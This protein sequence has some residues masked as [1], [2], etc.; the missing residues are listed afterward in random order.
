MSSKRPRLTDER[1]QELARRETVKHLSGQRL[2]RIYREVPVRT[3]WSSSV[4]RNYFE[5]T[6]RASITGWMR[7]VEHQK[8]FGSGAGTQPLLVNNPALHSGVQAAFTPLAFGELS[9]SVVATMRRNIGDAQHSS[10]LA[11]RQGLARIRNRNDDPLNKRRLEVVPWGA[12]VAYP[13]ALVDNPGDATQRCRRGLVRA[14]TPD[15]QHPWFSSGCIPLFYMDAPTPYNYPLPTVTHGV[16]R[17]GDSV[18]SKFRELKI[19]IE[20]FPYLNNVNGEGNWTNESHGDFFTYNLDP[21]PWARVIIFKMKRNFNS[22]AH[23]GGL[24]PPIFPRAAGASS[25]TDGRETVQSDVTYDTPQYGQMCRTWP[26]SAPGSNF[27]IIEDFV[28]DLGRPQLPRLGERHE[29]RN[30]TIPDA[31]PLM[32]GY[33]LETPAWNADNTHADAH[34]ILRPLD[35]DGMP[36]PYNRVVIKREYR[37]NGRTVSWHHTA[38]DPPSLEAAPPRD[39]RVQPVVMITPDVNPRLQ[40]FGTPSQ[41]VVLD[42]CEEQMFLTVVT[43]CHIS[44]RPGITDTAINEGGVNMYPGVQALCGGLD[45][46]N[47]CNPALVSVET[48]WWYADT[49]INGPPKD[50]KI[51]G[52]VEAV[53]GVAP[54]T[55]MDLDTEATHH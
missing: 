8:L 6:S 25:F 27:T 35:A 10:W 42:M 20:P 11:T 17:H 16:D 15:I 26:S 49:G 1:V 32:S 5:P 23:Q 39:E 22:D 18:Y 46:A 47:I 29:V 55:V 9:S 43:G 13:S 41:N 54:R 48:K 14:P 50:V 31:E 7:S 52:A 53:P 51:V 38:L 40:T 30:P 45:P 37:D 28:V 34:G 24:F 36:H 33:G 4:P 3:V 2:D 21:Q 19:C 12:C 44:L